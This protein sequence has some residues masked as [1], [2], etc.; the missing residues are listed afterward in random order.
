MRRGRIVAATLLGWL[1][2]GVAA[3][4]A[5]AHPGSG[6]VVEFFARRKAT[7]GLCTPE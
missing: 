1:I 6:I 7:K 3:P 2:L 4:D 5:Q